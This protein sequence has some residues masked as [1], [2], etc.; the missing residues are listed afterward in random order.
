MIIGRYFTY[1]FLVTGSALF[2]QTLQEVL[3]ETSHTAIWQDSFVR[4]TQTSSTGY[5]DGKLMR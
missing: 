1:S 2:M 5:L 4:Q 3:R